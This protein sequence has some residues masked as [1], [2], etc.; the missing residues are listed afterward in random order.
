MGV[1]AAIVGLGAVIMGLG[2]VI[3]GVGAV[4]M[5]LGAIIIGVGAVIIGIVDVVMMP[6]AVTSCV[7]IGNRVRHGGCEMTAAISRYTLIIYIGEWRFLVAYSEGLA[8]CLS[9]L[10]WSPYGAALR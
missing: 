6:V 10:P 5:G 9:H 4:I 1:G 8:A 2:A 3:I 7:V